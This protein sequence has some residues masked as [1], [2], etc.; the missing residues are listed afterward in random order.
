M[1]ETNNKYNNCLDIFNPQFDKQP[2]IVIIGAGGIGCGTTFALAQMWFNNITVI[3]FDEVE[4]KNTSSQLY[5][6]DDVWKL[7]VDALHD[8]VLAF[9]WVSIHTY[10]S[11]YEPEFTKDADIVIMA[12]DNM[13]VRRQIA[14]GLTI[15]TQRMLDCRMAA[16]AFEI[17]NYIPVYELPLYLRT[18]YTDEEASPVTCTYKSVSYNTFAIA[19]YITRFVIWIIKNDPVIINKSQFTVDLHNLLVA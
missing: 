19:S 5:R 6:E 11:K 4:L 9:T 8:N 15:K 12:V 3:D 17:Y 10:N 18:W 1:T 7:K 14:E 16:E 13:A 2:K